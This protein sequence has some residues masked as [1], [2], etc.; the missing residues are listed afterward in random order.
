R[1][2]RTSANGAEGGGPPAESSTIVRCRPKPA[3]MPSTPETSAAVG[4]RRTA[5]SRVASHRKPKKIA[6]PPAMSNSHT[7]LLGHAHERQQQD[8]A[9]ES[10]CARLASRFRCVRHELDSPARRLTFPYLERSSD[11]IIPDAV[12]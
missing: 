10:C 11:L 12:L 3:P 4:P 2:T 1:G 8:L 7:A 9:V 5:S 6:S